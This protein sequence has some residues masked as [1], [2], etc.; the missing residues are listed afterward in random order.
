M[1][2]KIVVF[3]LPD[4]MPLLT[5]SRMVQ[6]FLDSL[7]NLGYD[8]LLVPESAEPE[9]LKPLWNDPDILGIFELSEPNPRVLSGVNAERIRVIRLEDLIER[10]LFEMDEVLRSMIYTQLRHVISRGRKHPVIATMENWSIHSVEQY[11][12]KLIYQVC[13]DLGIQDATIM[14]IKSEPKNG[15]W[16][17]EPETAS[18]AVTEILQ[19][20]PQTDCFVCA[21]DEVALAVTN[22]L[23]KT[24][25]MVPADI[26][27]VSLGVTELSALSDPP[28]TSVS[29]NLNMVGMRGA[30][31]I[32][33]LLGE[34][35]DYLITTPTNQILTV[36]SSS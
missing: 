9:A 17:M 13:E 10:G 7:Q 30:L 4:H 24:G 5:T 16:T 25:N 2:G 28:L 19:E 20:R 22:A 11:F 18:E 26:S 21:D 34:N 8:A 6:S 27:V 32:L 35:V 15:H 3:V 1:S 23:W 14:T 12:K 29:M 33:K 31:A 36:R